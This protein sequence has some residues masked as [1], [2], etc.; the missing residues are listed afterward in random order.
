MKCLIVEDDPVSSMALEQIISRYGTFD[1]VDNGQTA[2][3][4]FRQAHESN[5]PYDLI[6][7]DILVPGIDGL[8][9]VQNIRKIEAS[10]NI[11]LTQRAK[12]IMTTALVDPRTVMKALYEADAN[13][14]LAKPIKLLKFENALRTL[15]LIS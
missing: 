10:M 12:V 9:S 1:T 5:S 15:K 3:D 2:V 4:R 14:Y 7:M 6:I 11:S 8:Q 13:S